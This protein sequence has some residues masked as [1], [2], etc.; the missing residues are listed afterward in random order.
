MKVIIFYAKYGGGHLSAARSIE[1][2]IKT[3]YNGIEVEL[4]DFMEY[5]NKEFNKITTKAY[6]EMA[7]KVPKA[8]G[9][10]YW[11]SEK[12]PLAHISTTSNK[13][14]SIRLHKLLQDKA[15]DLIICT[16]P[17]ASQMCGYLTKHHKLNTQIA[18]IL[19]DFASHDQWLVYNEYI[20]KLFVANQEMKE[21]LISKGIPSNKVFVTGIPISDRFLINYDKSSIFLDFNL[22]PNKKTVL[23]FGGGEFGLGKSY[24]LKVFETFV[25]NS[26]DL[27]IIAISGKNQKLKEAFEYIVIKYNKEANVHIF[28]YINMVPELMSISNL[29]V[30]KPGGL[31]T[32]ESLAS[33][34]PI[35]VI[36][37]IPGQEE[38]NATYLVKHNA[39]IWLKKDD[40]IEQIVTNLLTDSQ[41]LDEMSKNAKSISKPNA[42]D[43]ICKI[44]LP[45]TKKDI[46]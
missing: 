28:E 7:K 9:S 43:D 4:I 17:F 24:T 20:N 10:I 3:N 27:Q 2:C 14:L 34:L 11:K 12:G 46:S 32:S 19:T 31:T 30:T 35:V 33:G 6:A 15:P 29:V 25:K 5:V 26:A 21:T 13:L 38:E 42:T 37:P 44:L 16:H 8:Y 23:F 39:A 22:S 40:D 1:N 36:N 45:N 41:K 18:T